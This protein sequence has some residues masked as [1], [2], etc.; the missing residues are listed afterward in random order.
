[1]AFRLA[2]ADPGAFVAVAAVEA[3]PVWTC[4]SLDPPVSLQSI[5][6]SGDPIVSKPALDDAMRTWSVLEGCIPHRTRLRRRA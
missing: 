3:A 5:T 2:C 1:M 4:P 6:S